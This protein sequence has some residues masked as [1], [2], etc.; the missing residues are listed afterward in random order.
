MELYKT[1]GVLNDIL[2]E[3]IPVPEIRT[4]ELGS[5]FSQVI[6]TLNTSPFI[7]PTPEYPYVSLRPCSLS[8]F[9]AVLIPP[10]VIS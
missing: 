9:G 3:H 5:G 8:F 7:T 10:V 6:S 1:L 4:C 2:R